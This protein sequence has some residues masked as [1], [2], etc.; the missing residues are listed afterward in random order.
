MQQ[1]LMNRRQSSHVTAANQKR[2][3]PVP[4]RYLTSDTEGEDLQQ[5]AA[6]SLGLSPTKL[7]RA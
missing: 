2:P 4:V 1:R 3:S 7:S 5:P 6:A